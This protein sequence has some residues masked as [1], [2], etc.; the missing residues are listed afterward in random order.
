MTETLAAD[1]AG[2]SRAC[3]LLDAGG[4][5][6]FPTETVYGLGGDA[7]NPA[8]VAGIFAAKGRPA[9]NPL[10]AHVPN[11]AAAEREGVF[12]RLA[13]RLA[14]RFWPG[15]LTLVLPLRTGART[16]ELA[17]AGLASIGLR[18]PDHPV[19]LALLD[20]F[21]RPIAGPSANVSGHVSPTTA[22]HVLADLGGRIGAVIDGG[23]TG[24]GIESTII[25]CVDG[26]LHLLRPGFITREGLEEAAG[27]RILNARDDAHAPLSPGRLASHYAPRTPVRLDADTVS[28]DEVLLTFGRTDVAG[29]GAARSVLNLSPTG[30]L[31]QAAANLYAYL[32]ELDGCAATAI[33]VSPLPQTG[34]GEAI[35][36]RLKRAATEGTF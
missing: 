18:C 8:A 15:P 32:R 28:P 23:A 9:F 33:A 25:A 3:E 34:L 2:I 17:R 22:Q 21:G 10:I 5:V 20:A 1:L 31:S 12:D 36:D 13:L 27:T 16:C 35:A 26:T 7:T 29:A 6:A 30:D 24:V 19:A 4:T 11:L 14:E